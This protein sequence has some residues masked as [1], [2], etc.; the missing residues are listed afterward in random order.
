MADIELLKSMGERIYTQR[1][2]LKMTQEELAER[3]GVSTQMISNLE[4]GK[5]AIRPEN[6]LK[7]CEALN[8][9]ADYVLTGNGTNRVVDSITEK[10]AGLSEEELRMV[11][12]MIDYMKSKK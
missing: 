3:I 12:E 2:A 4:T 7:I 1:K 8:I 9:S 10:L 11:R 6:L 5:K